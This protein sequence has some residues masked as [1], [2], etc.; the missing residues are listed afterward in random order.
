MNFFFEGSY[1]DQL[2]NSTK[3]EEY[4][5]IIY[6]LKNKYFV[7]SFFFSYKFTFLSYIFK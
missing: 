5:L 2:D 3:Q 7:F 1:I 6:S 4:F